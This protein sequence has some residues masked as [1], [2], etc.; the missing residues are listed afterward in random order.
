MLLDQSVN[1]LTMRPEGRKR[2]LLVSAYQS[3]VTNCIGRKDGGH[4]AMNAI[5]A[6]APSA[7]SEH[8]KGNGA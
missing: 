4:S 2:P 8:P 5:Q 1:D 3:A 6:I 7:I